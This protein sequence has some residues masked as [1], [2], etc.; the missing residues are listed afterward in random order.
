MFSYTIKATYI[1]MMIIYLFIS[2]LAIENFQ[3]HFFW[4]FLF[5]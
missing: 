1:D 3:K 4:M 5:H 2:F